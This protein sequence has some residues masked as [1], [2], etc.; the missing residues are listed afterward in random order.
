MVQNRRP[1]RSLLS[2][3]EMALAGTIQ[4]DDTGYSAVVAGAADADVAA[5]GK[6]A[7]TKSGSGSA[8]D[9]PGGRKAGEAGSVS[10]KRMRV[11]VHFDRFAPQ[12]DEW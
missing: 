4:E 10:R 1:S 7:Q 2:A 6:A 3:E 11:R 8:G 5:G 9:G 12:W